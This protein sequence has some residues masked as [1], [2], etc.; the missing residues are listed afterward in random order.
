MRAVRSGGSARLAVGVLLAACAVGSGLTG[1]LHDALWQDEIGTERVISQPTVGAALH[2]IVH[3]ESTPPAFFL[4][5]RAADRAATGLKP[6]SRA[7][8]IRS[9]S[10]VFSLG[11]AVLTFVLAYQLM[12]LWAAALSGLLISFGSVGV[13]YGSLSRA[14]ALLAFACVAFALMLE[15]AAARPG[16]LRLALLAGVVA[17]GSLTHYFFLFTLGAGVLW[18]L[19]SGLRGATIARVGAALAVGL[20]PLA[21]WS[22]YWLRQYRNGIYATAPSINFAHF[23]GL[24]PSLFTSQAIVSS[25]SIAVTGLVTLAALVSAAFLLRR[26][27]GRL[28]GLFLLAPFL[29]VSLLAWVTG[30]RVYRDRNLIGVAPFAAIA[31]AWGCASLPWRRVSYVAGSLVGALVI[32]GFAYGQ[33]ALGRTPYDRIAHEMMRQGFRR[34]EPIFWFGSWGGHVPVGWYL[35]LHETAK[36][37]PPLVVSHPSQGACSELEV[38]ARTETSRLWLERHRKAIV[39]ETALPSFGDVP[40]GRRNPDLIVARLR[41]SPGIL[42]PTEV[43]DPDVDRWP[44]APTNGFLFRVAGTPSPCLR[45]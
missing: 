15:R 1:A 4:L 45:S 17:L 29:T 12:P 18:L 38:V 9:L 32:S 40:L 21:V 8:A 36:T 5:A 34:D 27:N 13:V 23:L 2:V 41:W 43:V 44:T 28:C 30:E 20:I 6:E 7:R 11:C 37:D 35:A 14:Y 31:L 25:T 42:T 3:R 33:I 22:P 10:I 19:V 39:A 16:F 26:P 24:L